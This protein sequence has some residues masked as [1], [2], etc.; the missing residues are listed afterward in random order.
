MHMSME[1]LSSAGMFLM[2]TMG[3]P[4]VQGPTAV[5]GMQ[6][7]GVSAPIAAAVAAATWGLAM[8]WHIP[9]GMMFFIG[10]LSMMVAAGW[11][12]VSTMF[13]GV[14]TIVPGAIPIE[15]FNI[16]PLQTWGTA[17]LCSS[18]CVEDTPSVGGGNCAPPVSV[19][20]AGGAAK[21]EAGRSL[22]LRA[23]RPGS[24]AQG[25][26]LVAGLGGA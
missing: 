17:T 26:G 9:K 6:G 7:C 11:L 12:L 22:V 19:P 2:S 18:S 8:L 4:G 13:S 14:T 15:H 23:R 5:M 3:A 16:A 24:E 21:L 10:M 20:E 25:E 1:D